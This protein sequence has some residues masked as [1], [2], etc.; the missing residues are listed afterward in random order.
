MY[1]R[2]WYIMHQC[3]YVLTAESANQVG[4]QFDSLELEELRCTVS[5]L[6]GSGR[7]RLGFVAEE[8]GGKFMSLRSLTQTK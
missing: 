5:R 4:C 1:N 6:A 7:A 3:C 2:V 8:T